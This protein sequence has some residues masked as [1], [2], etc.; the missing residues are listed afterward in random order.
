MNSQIELWLRNK[1][2][3][4]KSFNNYLEKGI[5]K[6][7]ENSNLSKLHMRRARLDI[8][9][10]GRLIE[11]MIEHSP[12][13]VVTSYYSAYHSAMALLVFKNYTSKS[14]L[15]TLCALIYLYYEY[16]LDEDD[17]LK[18][19]K[20]SEDSIGDFDEFKEKREMANYSVAKDFEV[21]V[22][23]NVRANALN[24]INRV[25]EILEVKNG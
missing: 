17:I 12:W 3:V 16:G 15:A 25:E 5:L 14:H 6:L 19:H 22:A 8:E 23:K 10:A 1:S 4:E 11:E 18:F 2:S 9:L 20:L 24:F 21:L 13:V 7:E